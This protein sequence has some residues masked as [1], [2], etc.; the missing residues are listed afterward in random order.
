MKLEMEFAHNQ[1]VNRIRV[2]LSNTNVLSKSWG[3]KEYMYIVA[4]C[5]AACQVCN[6]ATALNCTSCSSGY[7]L[8]GTVC[9]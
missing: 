8:S 2:D 1:L 7:V 5:H 3:I 9:N 4:T 6:D